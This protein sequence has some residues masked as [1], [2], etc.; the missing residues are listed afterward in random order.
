MRDIRIADMTMRGG[1]AGGELSLSFKEKLELIRELGRL[2]MDVIE[3][4]P[5]QG[6]KS[7]QVLIRTAAT[8]VKN[9]ILSCPTG[10][11]EESVELAWGTVMNAA[12]P[13]LLVSV[14][15]SPV[16]MEYVSHTKPQSGAGAGGP[17][18]LRGRRALRRR[19]ICGG[20]RVPRR[21]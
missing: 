16:Q 11:S 3:F 12:K 20:R 4:A 1:A 14:P 13:R 7:E 10:L 2:G 19:G 15:L 21:F 5:P 17:P 8:L 6:S 9:S 18:C